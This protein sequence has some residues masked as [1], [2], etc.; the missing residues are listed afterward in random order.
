MQN[1]QVRY[2]ER[3][4]VDYPHH[5]GELVGCCAEDDE[6]SELI[7][8]GQARRIAAEWQAPGNAY[9]ALQHVGEITDGLLDEIR[10]DLRSAHSPQEARKDLRALRKWAQAHGVGKVSGWGAWDDTPVDDDGED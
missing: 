7:N 5:D 6:E 8:K 1:E 9:S 10:S 4:H 3:G 2:D